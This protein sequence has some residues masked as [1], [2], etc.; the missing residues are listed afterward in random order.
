MQNDNPILTFFA[1]WN[2]AMAGPAPLQAEGF[3]RFFHDD[4]QLIVNGN[5]R[6][7]S[8]EQMAVHYQAI[9]DR[10][11]LVEMVLPVEESFATESRAFVHCR[12][13]ARA[14][15][16]ESAEEAMAYAVI[17]GGKMR[18]LRVVSLSV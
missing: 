12:T 9:A 8:P 5:L 7:S 18:L 4:G 11:D 17:D 14:G 10:L 3:A 6:A 2:G 13:R 16:T 1:W 15:E